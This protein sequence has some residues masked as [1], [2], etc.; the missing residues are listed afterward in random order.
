[1]RFKSLDGLRGVAALVVVLSHLANAFPA[2]YLPHPP[3]SSGAFWLSFFAVLK[4]T[5]LRILVAGR[6]AV[7]VFFVLSGFVLC[8]SQRS[9]DG[10]LPY[11]A[12]R[13]FRI[14][15]PF[16]F[17]VLFAAALYLA[18]DPHWVD[19]A[20]Q[21][22]NETSWT[23]PPTA[24]YLASNLLMSGMTEFPTLNNPTWSL[25]HELRISLAFP[26]LVLLLLRS[27]WAAI[28][29]STIVSALALALPSSDPVLYTVELTIGYTCFFVAGAA[30]AISVD[31][32]RA[33]LASL[34]RGSV[35][36]LWL[37]AFTLLMAPMTSN[38]NSFAPGVG[39]VLLVP[40]C[41]SSRR[42]AAILQGT[43]PTW[44]GRVSY[45]LYL[46]HMPIL[47]ALVHL[48]AGHLPLPALCLAALVISLGLAEVC[49]RVVE[50][51]SI[52]LGRVCS[53]RLAVT[54]GRAE[55]S[56]EAMDRPSRA[57]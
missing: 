35:P 13:L 1:M 56:N 3:Y 34:P 32:V 49:Y 10:Y 46:I 40:L 12:K 51:P 18:V 6:A 4:Y 15:P 45:S 38:L 17:A 9:G 33:M 30:L 5:P 44:L 16:V 25:V 2:F 57:G 41:I 31:R 22:L 52:M 54:A 48:G 14:V 7:M 39:A 37:A 11:L 29:V 23:E 19:G 43:V 42:A 21:H 28:V 36:L 8:L 50:H 55:P 20:S 24:S 53:R 27:F 26:L 47:L